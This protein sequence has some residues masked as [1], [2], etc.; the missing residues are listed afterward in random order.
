MIRTLGL[1]CAYAGAQPLR[2]P[3]VDLP[4]GGRLL[5]QG[6]SGSGKSTWLSLVAGLRTPSAGQVCVA[7]QALDGLRGSALDA[8]RARAIGFLP[9][10]LHLSH[11]LS[12]HDNL[13]LAYFAAGLPRD[14]AAIAQA[15]HPLGVGDLGARYPAQLSGG[16]AQRVALARAVLLRPAVLL[17]DEPTASLDDEAAAQALD[18]LQQCCRACGASLVVATHDRR[19]HQALP[20]A[21]VLDLNEIGLQGNQ[22]GRKQL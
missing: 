18:L 1:A 19:V 4:Q 9:Q 2:F 15:L 8:W 13:A 10:R 11:A 21:Q 12:V 17:A 16:Q 7:G 20:G 14:D 22:D 5:V 6:R 3:D